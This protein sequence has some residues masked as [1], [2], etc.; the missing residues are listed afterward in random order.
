VEAL[1]KRLP[2]NIELVERPE[3]IEDPTFAAAAAQ[4]LIGLIKGR[5]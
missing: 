2:R 1:R 5:A 3:N 4:K